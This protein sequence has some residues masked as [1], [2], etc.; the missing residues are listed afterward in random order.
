[1]VALPRLVA[2][3]MTD[4]VYPPAPSL[5]GV[6]TVTA[7]PHTAPRAAAAVGGRLPGGGV[8][9]AVLHANVRGVRSEYL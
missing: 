7:A 3:T 1:M 5:P 4:A 9:G 2:D 8:G 6:D